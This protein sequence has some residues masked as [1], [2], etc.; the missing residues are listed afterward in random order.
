MWHIA[1]NRMYSSIHQT[2][3]SDPKSPI[4]GYPLCAVLL[5]VVLFLSKKKG[6]IFP[7]TV[8]GESVYQEATRF[9][10]QTLEAE[11]SAL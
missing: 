2:H 8:L 9:A 10:L 5:Y 6:I 3:I 11:V 4:Y 7:G 1:S